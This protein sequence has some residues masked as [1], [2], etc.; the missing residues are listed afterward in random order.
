VY[1]ETSKL[2]EIMKAKIFLGVLCV[3]TA[4]STFSSESN[5]FK[6]QVGNIEVVTMVENRGQGRSSVLVNPSQANLQKYLPDGTYNSEVNTF[7][8]KTPTHTILIDTGFGTTLFDNLRS[9]GVSADQI[10]AVLITHSHGDHVNGLVKDGKALFPNA[11][12]YLAASEKEFWTNGASVLALYGNKVH[13]FLPGELGTSNQDLLPGI[14][15]IASFGHTPGHTTFMVSSEAK[16]LLI[17]GDLVHVEDIQI[18][19]PEQS[20][21]YDSDSKAAAEIRKKIFEYAVQNNIAVA[22]MHLRYPAVGFLSSNGSGFL[23]SA[24]R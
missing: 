16:Q 6:F 2:E 17:F 21:S 8:V 11:K 14:K 13:T 9:L 22:G 3:M 10:D 7:L 5:I 1:N 19:V 24:A 18:S 12:V 20:V 15:A 4:A 23:F